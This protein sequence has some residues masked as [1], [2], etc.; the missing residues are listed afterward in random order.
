MGPRRN[1]SRSGAWHK[2]RQE[3]ERQQNARHERARTRTERKNRYSEL[4]GLALTKSKLIVEAGDSPY[5]DTIIEK[6]YRLQ[7]QTT[8]SGSDWMQ[9]P[10]FFEPE[11]PA[12]ADIMTYADLRNPANS[13]EMVFTGVISVG[14]KTSEKFIGLVR[15]HLQLIAQ[16]ERTRREQQI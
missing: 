11:P 16:A 15:S 8:A 4:Q 1:G 7:R 6:F 3:T 5:S 10:T 13:T 2:G 12:H 9:H 14:S